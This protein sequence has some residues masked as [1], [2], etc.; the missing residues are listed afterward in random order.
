MLDSWCSTVVVE[1][2]RA[3]SLLVLEEGSPIRRIAYT[4]AL[5]LDCWPDLT[6]N[7]NGGAESPVRD[8]RATR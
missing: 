1:G 4:M 6:T 8:L 5:I 2:E 7:C 3:S